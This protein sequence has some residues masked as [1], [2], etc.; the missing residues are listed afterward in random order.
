MKGGLFYTRQ[1]KGAC[2]LAVLRAATQV[3]YITKTAWTLNGLQSVG[4][5]E[6]GQLKRRLAH[7]YLPRSKQ[8]D[9]ERRS[10]LESI[11]TISFGLL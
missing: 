4:V 1:A 5:G 10:R 8:V 7:I 9:K 2:C 3:C 11:E 6:K